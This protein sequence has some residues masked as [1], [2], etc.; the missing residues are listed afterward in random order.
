MTKYFELLLDLLEIQDKDPYIKIA[1]I[2]EENPD[3]KL[4]VHHQYFF[5]FE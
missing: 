4:K 1:K 5:I 3:K 2:I